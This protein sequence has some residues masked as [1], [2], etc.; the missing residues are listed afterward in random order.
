VKAVQITE[1]VGAG[2][3][4]PLLVLAGPC[5]VEERDFMLRVAE[6]VRDICERHGVGFVFKSSFDKA[7]RSSSDTARGPGMDE[8][9]ATLAAVKEELSVP[10]VTD[11]HESWQAK[12]TAEVADVLQIPAFLSRQTD[13]L[14]AAAETGR[15]VNVKKGQFLSPPEMGNVVAKL[16]GAGSDRILL[17]ERGT[18]FGYN[19]LVVDFRGL[20]QL[21][22]FGYPVVFDA[23]HSVQLPGGLGGAS[24][25]QREYVSHLARAA[26][27]VGID[28]LFVEVHPNPD[29]APSDGPNQV[30]P[31]A[32]DRLLSEVLAVREALRGTGVAEE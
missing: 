8:G 17:T 15:V 9:L 4:H 13:L 16:E 19:N 7:N 1:Q 28:G 31:E 27:A 20:P 2:P 26:A 30:T 11:I 23:T 18:T 12:P 6:T 25:G 29:S 24:G 21:A 22:A 5:V 14:V 32:F 3:D 10:V